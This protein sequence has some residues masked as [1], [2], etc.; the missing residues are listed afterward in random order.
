MNV[1]KKIE[2]FLFK[3]NHWKHIFVGLVIGLFGFDFYAGS[4]A[5]VIAA[6]AAEFKDDQHGGKFDIVDWLCTAIAGVAMSSVWL[7]RE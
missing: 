7:L 3:S 2:S 1:L 6:T 4:Y 5:A